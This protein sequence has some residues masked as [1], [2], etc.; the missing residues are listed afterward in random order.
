MRS[1]KA[2]HDKMFSSILSAPMRFFDLNSSG[3]ILNRISTDMGSV[4]EILPP[5]LMDVVNNLSDLCSV[6]VVITIIN[7]KMILT[8]V[9]SIFL[10]GLIFKFHLRASQDLKRLEGIRKFQKT[11]YFASHRFILNKIIIID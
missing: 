5:T 9:A 1:S 8:V 7:P 10:F 2:L 6:L 3:R 4:D 11:I